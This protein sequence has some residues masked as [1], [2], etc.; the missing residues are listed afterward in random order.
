MTKILISCKEEL[1]CMDATPTSSDNDTICPTC[2]GIMTYKKAPF[3]LHGKLVGDFDSVVCGKCGYSLLTASGYDK[4][5]IEAQKLKLVGPEEELNVGDLKEEISY[6][7]PPII[8][9]DRISEF[10]VPVYHLVTDTQLRQ[11]IKV[12]KIEVIEE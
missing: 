1:L 4:A 9:T 6:I 10:N 8:L 5:I 3:Y 2:R 11:D 12:K 7:Y